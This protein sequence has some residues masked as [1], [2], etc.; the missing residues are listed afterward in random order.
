[1]VVVIGVFVYLLD[2]VFGWIINYIHPVVTAAT[3]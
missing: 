3:K 2:Q 1:L